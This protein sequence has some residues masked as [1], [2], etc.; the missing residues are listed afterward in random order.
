MYKV[1]GLYEAL[2]KHLPSIRSSKEQAKLKMLYGDIENDFDFKERLHQSQ[3]YISM[4]KYWSEVSFLYSVPT[5]N[6]E[7]IYRE[8]KGINTFLSSPTMEK[9][10]IISQYINTVELEIKGKCEVLSSFY[11]DIVSRINRIVKTGIK[12]GKCIYKEDDLKVYY[13]SMKLETGKDKAF[14]NSLRD[15]NEY[16]VVLG[17]SDDEVLFIF[18]LDPKSINS[19]LNFRDIKVTRKGDKLYFCFIVNGNCKVKFYLEGDDFV[20]NML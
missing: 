6:L 1:K 5:I 16:R 11:S 4:Y 18:L 20:L 9:V 19:L 15:S 3:A 13:S 7:G 10:C 14:N 8:I 17:V 2:S 12:S